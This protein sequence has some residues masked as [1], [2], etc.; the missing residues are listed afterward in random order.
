MRSS[1]RLVLLLGLA[2]EVG[3][4]PAPRR[5]SRRWRGG[6][7]RLR[8]GTPLL[9][10]RTGLLATS[11]ASVQD[12]ELVP[13]RARSARRA[14]RRRAA[15]PSRSRP[16]GEARRPSRRGKRTAPGRRRARRG[17][18]SGNR[19]RRRARRSRSWAPGPRRA[20][21][22]RRGRPRRA[23]RRCRVEL[24]A[25][26]ASAASRTGSSAPTRADA[27]RRPRSRA[28]RPLSWSPS[29]AAATSST[30]VAPML[31]QEA[32]G[33]GRV[34]LRVP[35]LDRDE[36]PVVGHLLERAASRRADGS[37]SAAR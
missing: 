17:R 19:G 13:C 24:A 6:G 1:P 30:R 34:E 31:P 9:P 29:L 28:R 11:A 15:S 3:G 12:V 20:R 22:S 10:W 16:P 21:A 25:E 7:R 18:C 8:S 35:G 5:R 36:E 4:E 26:S 33:L 27:R 14:A 23:R 2:G 32:L 37:A